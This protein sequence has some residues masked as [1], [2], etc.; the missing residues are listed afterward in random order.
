MGRLIQ[1]PGP[2]VPGS[3]LARGDVPALLAAAMRYL[4]GARVDLALAA[5]QEVLAREP[6]NAVALGIAGLIAQVEGRHDVAELLFD[7][8]IENA[9]GDPVGYRRK[10]ALR[11]EEDR[12][13]EAVVLLEYAVT[14]APGDPGTL[15]DLG[16]V[17][18]RSG[19]IERGAQALR[20]AVDLDQTRTD[21]RRQLVLIDSMTGRFECAVVGYR[22]LLVDDDQDPAEHLVVAGPLITVREWTASNDAVYTPITPAGAAA[23]ERPS[24]F[25]EDAPPP[26]AV[27]RP[28]TY[29]AEIPD[30]T[31]VGDAHV[32]VAP[33]GDLLLDLAGHPDAE[34]FELAEG[35]LRVAQDGVGL[36]DAAE[37]DDPLDAAIHLLGTSSR[38]YYHWLI[39]ML[40]RIASLEA[41]Y[42]AAGIAGV[43]FLVDQAC[44]RVPQL[45]DALAAVGGADR[46][47]VTLEPGRARR[48][49]RLILPSGLAWLPNNLRDGLVLR[50]Q[51][52]LITA[53]AV[54]FVRERVFAAV[55]PGSAGQA[56]PSESGRR[57]FLAKPQSRRLLNAPDLEPV[58]AEFGFDSV[59]PEMHSFARQVELFGGA[60]L[61]VAESGAA[62]ANILF[63]PPEARILVLCA[64]RWDHSIF[65]Q[66]A[67][68]LGQSLTYLTG[69]LV[70]G[71]HHKRYQSSFTVDP[72]RLRQALTWL[73]R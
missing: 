21:L 42:P 22:Q 14:R 15:A 56:I 48:V 11:V 50:A 30:A 73:A 24:Y 12:F 7:Q 27:E 71:S 8:A 72:D 45:M 32:V 5:A 68:S 41:G 9:P 33:S 34:R 39:E 60:A 63:A 64:D 19:Q 26:V 6:G 43:P 55:A 20:S 28:E 36:L 62:L 66:I 16:T 35:A 38:N 4:D 23:I 37:D 29:V 2:R 49:R 53:D 59:Q 52:S 54:R 13:D 31:V 1:F 25:G 70:E 46:P 51:D 10:A 57:I 44:T 17:L 58:L 65:S 67:A 40:P 18:L 69:S 3:S 47:L 61:I